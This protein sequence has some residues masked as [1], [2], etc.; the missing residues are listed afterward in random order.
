MV[1]VSLKLDAEGQVRYLRVEGH[2]GSD[3]RGK[4][5][6]CAAVS[7]VSVGAVNCLDDRESCYAISVGKGLLECQVLEEVSVHDRVVLEVVRREL[8]DLA[9]TYPDY[10]Q[11]QEERSL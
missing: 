7:A 11:Y 1:R 5:I 3:E 6:V 10:I 8:F 4:D 2:A 9:D